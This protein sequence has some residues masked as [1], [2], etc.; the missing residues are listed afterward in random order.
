MEKIHELL[1]PKEIT[2]PSNV[3]EA[4]VCEYSGMLATD[5]CPTT[6]AYFVEGTQPK[7]YCDASHASR[8]NKPT[9]TPLSTVAPVNTQALCLR[10]PLRLRNAHENQNGNN[11][12]TSSGINSGSSSSTN[13]GSSSSTNPGTNS[14][15]YD[16]NSG[17]S[18]SSNSG[19]LYEQGNTG[20]SESENTAGGAEE[21]TSS[22][23]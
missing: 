9:Q 4:Q 3:V 16:T 2:K 17:G 20:S 8:R 5:T 19:G 15:S 12:N 7:A 6:T 18:S 22:E 23:E 1:N 14:G 10:N 13:S 21:D 11:S